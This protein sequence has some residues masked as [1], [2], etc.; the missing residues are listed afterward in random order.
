LSQTYTELR[1]DCLAKARSAEGR[2][3]KTADEEI[4]RAYDRLAKSWAKLAGSIPGA[5]EK[6]PH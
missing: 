2:R 3:A 5:D 6:Q 4:W 1:S